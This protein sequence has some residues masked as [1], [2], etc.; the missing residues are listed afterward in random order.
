MWS[1]RI[2]LKLC[3]V[4][5]WLTWLPSCVSVSAKQP[6]P[7]ANSRN[8]RGLQY[9]HAR[10]YDRAIVEFDEAI[11]LAPD[12]YLAY[13]N[14]GS[15]YVAKREPDR[16]IQDYD[17]AIK[18]KPDSF[19]AFFGR[20]TAFHAKGDYVLEIQD[21]SHALRSKL[22]S[23]I[24]TIT[25][26]PADLYAA[27]LNNR[28]D[29]YFRMKDFEHAIRD[30]DRAI[31]LDPYFAM[32]YNARCWMRATANRD[33]GAALADCDYALRL[34]PDD[35]RSLDSRAFVH[36]RMGQFEQA[37]A[38]ASASLEHATGPA[39]KLG[40]RAAGTFYVRGLAKRRLGDLTGAD[41]DLASARGLDSQVDRK[42]AEYGVGP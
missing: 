35:P 19:G 30:Y 4:A 10:D 22:D 13:I 18:L 12:F 1:G 7:A 36:F 33:L 42:Y 17:Q 27:A 39:L 9:L 37:V 41:A 31:T 26:Q 32:A 34:Q 14:R 25:R 8:E 3:Y 21:L 20:S 29:A 15:V 28:G 5:F 38:D 23:S 24:Q 6:S 11:K 2:L 40:A 16:A